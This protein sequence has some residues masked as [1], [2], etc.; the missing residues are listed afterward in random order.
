MPWR[1]QDAQRGHDVQ[2]GSPAALITSRYWRA[3]AVRRTLAPRFDKEVSVMSTNGCRVVFACLLG[4][5]L[6]APAGAGTPALGDLGKVGAVDFPTSCSAD[7]QPEFQRGVALLHSFFYGEARRVFAAVAEREPS[8]AMA[9]WGVAMT[10]FHPLWAPPTPDEI[11][12]GLE[13]VER[14]EAANAKTA[15]E[16]DYIAAIATLYRAPPAADAAVTESCH[17]VAVSAVRR[18]EYVE[19]LASLHRRYPQDT[20]AAAFYAL[21]L[22]KPNPRPEDV[23]LHERAAAILHGFW[24]QHRDHPGLVHYLIHA[25]DYPPLAQRGLE[26][27][28]HYTQIAPWVPHALHMPSHIYTRLGMWEESLA[29]NRASAAAARAYGERHHPGTTYFEELHALDYL[30]YGHLQR[31]EDAEARAV[32]ERVQRV[33]KTWPESDMVLSYAA[34]SIPARYALERR[35]WAEAAALPAPQSHLVAAFPFNAAHTE[36]ARAIGQVHLGQ[37]AAAKASLARIG[38]LGAASDDPRFVYFRRQ[39]EIQQ[40]AVAALIAQAEGRSDEAVTMLRA[41]ADEDDALGKHPVSPG[42]IY[43]VRELLGDLLLELGRPQEARL[44]FEQSLRLNPGRFNAL[45]GAARASELAGALEAAQRH[46]RQLLDQSGDGERAELA[47][48]R[49]FLSRTDLARAGHSAP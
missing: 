15:R 14:A 2:R 13:A 49:R 30:A 45:R 19:A 9:H 36:F 26:A 41:A 34:G 4:C 44:A 11:K 18:D 10:W 7:V 5:A 25:Y 1:S 43:P 42:N 46:Y 37:T 38:E 27:A 29:S 31:G 17:G 22:L 39:L 33:D 21:S 20:E 47:A 8:C 48:A 16:R 24:Q 23:P 40:R 12:A 3:L 32:V 6:V 28:N 35:A